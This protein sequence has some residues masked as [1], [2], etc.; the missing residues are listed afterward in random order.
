MCSRL[1]AHHRTVSNPEIQSWQGKSNASMRCDPGIIAGRLGGPGSFGLIIAAEPMTIR[2]R[3]IGGRGLATLSRRGGIR[4]RRVRVPDRCTPRPG[5]ARYLLWRPCDRKDLLSHSV[6]GAG[7]SSRCLLW[8]SC[9]A[10]GGRDRTRSR[11]SAL[12][13]PPHAAS[14]NRSRPSLFPTLRWRRAR[15]VPTPDT[16]G[17]NADPLWLCLINRR[18][19]CHRPVPS[20]RD[21]GE[22]SAGTT[23]AGWKAPTAAS[24][25][26]GHCRLSAA[27]R[28]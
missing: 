10:G 23:R 7:L 28:S 24:R 3:I 9:R 25:H 19:E 12:D 20:S 18:R 5:T 11:R 14:R 1:T 27:G 8:A 17:M 26:A 22:A 4:T 16:L 21:E 6:S 13:L 15:R 2:V